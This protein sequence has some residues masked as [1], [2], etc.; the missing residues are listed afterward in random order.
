MRR[1]KFGV[2]FKAKDA[3][4]VIKEQNSLQEL[5]SKFELHL[6]QIFK[7]QTRIFRQF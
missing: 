5:V 1:R 2:S 4:A 7:L 6:N 3:I